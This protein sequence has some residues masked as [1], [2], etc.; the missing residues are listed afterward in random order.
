MPV[1]PPYVMKPIRVLLCNRHP[2]IRGELRQLLER[3]AGICVVGEAASAREAVVLTQF[4][5]PWIV[6]LDVQLAD[7][8][9]ISAARDICARNHD[10]KVILLS[11][12]TEEEYIRE[13]FKAGA[14]EYVLADAAQTD[15][16]DA[17]QTVAAGQRFL[18]PCI[19][20]AQAE[21]SGD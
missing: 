5:H 6:L 1:S 10:V 17:I 21:H 11:E 2:I 19:T 4:S 12:Y 7:G 15:L 8:S 9:G 20:S 13:A 3:S 16:I 18:S 14:R